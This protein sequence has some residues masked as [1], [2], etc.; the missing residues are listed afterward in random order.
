MKLKIVFKALFSAVKW[1]IRSKTLVVPIPVHK[2]AMLDLTETEISA[3]AVD[4]IT[5]VKAHAQFKRDYKHLTYAER[6]EIGL[7]NIK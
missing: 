2:P 7:L 3:M 6:R 1:F 5:R 4:A